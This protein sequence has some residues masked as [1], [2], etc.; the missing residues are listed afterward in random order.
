M[1]NIP[2]AYRVRGPS[3]VGGDARRF[4]NLARTL[5]TT[6]WKVRFYGSALG[7]VWSLLRPLMLFGIVYFVFAEV[8]DA[9]RGIPHYGVILLLAMIM[10]FFFSEVTGAGVTAMVDRES[11]LRKVGFPRA[12][13]P[14]AVALVAAMNLALNLVVLVVFVALTGVEPRWSWLLLPIPFALLLVFATGVSMLLSAL[15]VR[16]RDV[17]PIWEV[18]L[19]AF[20]YATPILYPIEAVIRQSETLAKVALLNPIATLV[21][22]SRH[23]LTGAPS[24]VEVLGSPAL[25]LVPFGMLVF[26]TW[27]GVRVFERLAPLAAEEL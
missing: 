2:E 15:Y 6:D 21:Q 4:W 22:E 13:V 12:V 14:L 19:Q 9:G 20:F 24:A 27:L 1:S 8:L 25:L 17:R 10:Y 7:Y 18:V 11:L 16:Y 26:V 5:A 3:A 23:L